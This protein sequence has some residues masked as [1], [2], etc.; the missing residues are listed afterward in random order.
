MW[1]SRA[2]SHPTHNVGTG[3]IDETAEIVLG[4][5]RHAGQNI[6]KVEIGIVAARAIPTRLGRCPK[7]RNDGCIFE[8][9]DGIAFLPSPLLLTTDKK[10]VSTAPRLETATIGCYCNTRNI[11]NNFSEINGLEIEI[12]RPTRGAN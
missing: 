9:G 7:A 4:L 3:K 11:R 6:P 8:L 2:A 1:L 10:R 12:P 5:R